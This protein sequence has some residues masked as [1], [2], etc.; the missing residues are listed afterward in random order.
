MSKSKN[1]LERP[2]GLSD[3]EYIKYLE[4]RV[5]ELSASSTTAKMY[6]GLKKQAD[7][8][9]VLLS[10]K[11]V[12]EGKEVDLFHPTSISDA[13]DKTFERMTKLFKEVWPM[14]KDLDEMEEKISPIMEFIDDKQKPGGAMEELLNESKEEK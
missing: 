7:D 4:N 6:R 2:K 8:L 13:S 12:V 9:A 3:A 5:F 11:I 14:L 1:K 10:K